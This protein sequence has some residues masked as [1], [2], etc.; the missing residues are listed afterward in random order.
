MMFVGRP[1]PNIQAAHM[2]EPVLLS[3]FEHAL[4]KR[5]GT[6]VRKERQ[7]IEANHLWSPKTRLPRV[8]CRR[9]ALAAPCVNGADALRRVRMLRE[10]AGAGLWRTGRRV[11][12]K[13]KADVREASPLCPKKLANLD[14]SPTADSAAKRW[15]GCYR[16]HP[17]L[18]DLAVS[19]KLVSH[20]ASPGPSRHRCARYKTRAM[21]GLPG[22][23]AWN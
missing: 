12:D 11:L 15:S 2:N 22:L 1:V 23:L 18:R 8:L 9:N 13:A 7:Y 21:R 4:G 6:K 14:G 5:A 16:S 10:W 19:G 20:C 3:F 17:S